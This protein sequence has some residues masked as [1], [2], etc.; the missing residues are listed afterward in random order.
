MTYG[1][2][3]IQ[4]GVGL[5]LKHDR[6]EPACLKPLVRSRTHFYIIDNTPK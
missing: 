1:V 4:I 2:L 3:E 5:G 6:I